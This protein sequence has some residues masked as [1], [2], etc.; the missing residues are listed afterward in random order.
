MRLFIALTPPAG[1]LDD[2]D[3]AF[4]PYRAAFGDL[5]WTSRETWHVTLAFLGEVSAESAERLLPRL[6]RGA[7]RHPAFELRVAGAGA[8]PDPGRATVLWSGITGNRRALGQLAMTVSAAARRA[9]APPPDAGR[10]YHPHL[11]LARAR[12]RTSVD[13]RRV[14]TGLDDYQGPPWTA[15]EISLIRSTL[16]SQPRYETIGTWKL[17]QEPAPADLRIRRAVPADAE[18]ITRVFLASRAAAMP[19]LPRL[20]TDEQTRS[21]IETAVLPGTTTWVAERGTPPAIV[22]FASLSGDRSVLDHL[23]LHPDAQHEGVGSALLATVKEAA[24]DGLSLHVFQR[25]HA[26]RRFYEHHGFRPGEL[27]D[28]SRNEEN[29]PDMTYHWSAGRR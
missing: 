26:A 20:H 15:G 25:N 11:T 12:G 8:F 23:Y 10:R 7:R 16:G 9:G 28:G 14:V 3:T 27:S 1:V 13:V 5:R 29:E 4:A 2:L 18:E 19:Y 6:E 17:R 24:P 22:G 21:W